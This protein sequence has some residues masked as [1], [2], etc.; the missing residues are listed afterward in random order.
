MKE[1]VIRASFKQKE[2]AHGDACIVYLHYTK[3]NIRGQMQTGLSRVKNK[4]DNFLPS[5]SF[6]AS[7]RCI[8]II[9]FFVTFIE[10]TAPLRRIRER[11]EGSKLRAKAIGEVLI[12]PLHT[13]LMPLNEP[14]KRKR[15]RCLRHDKEDARNNQ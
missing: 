3:K 15:A 11:K 13:R 10:P 6:R 4:T 14:V 8:K 1:V 12:L 2:K 5:L 9:I 7:R